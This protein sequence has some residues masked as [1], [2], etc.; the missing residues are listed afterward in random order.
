M[1]E[2]DAIQIALRDAIQITPREM[3][4]IWRRRMRHL[5]GLIPKALAG[6]DEIINDLA[7]ELPDDRWSCFPPDGRPRTKYPYTRAC[8]ARDL[9]LRGHPEARRILIGA[10]SHCHLTTIGSFGGVHECIMVFEQVRRDDPHI[11]LVD[12]PLRVWRGQG[13]ANPGTGMS[14]TSDPAKARWFV[15]QHWPL[16]GGVGGYEIIER[17]V[18]SDD[19]L[20]IV[21]PDEGRDGEA[22]VLLRP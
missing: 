15:E 7:T 20:A 16:R 8:L 14:W 10:W 1:D 12:G 22:E 5:K 17:V 6:D 18:S 9:A 21:G 3:R 13:V 19:I 4:E 11:P 2:D